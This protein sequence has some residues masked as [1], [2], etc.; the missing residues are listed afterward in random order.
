[1]AFDLS[2]VGARF[3]RLRRHV[4]SLM[5]SVLC[6]S[7]LSTFMKGSSSLSVNRVVHI[8]KGWCS[9][10]PIAKNECLGRHSVDLQSVP[11]H[12]NRLP[13]STFANGQ[14]FARCRFHSS[15][16]STSTSSHDSEINGFSTPGELSTQQEQKFTEQPK[17]HYYDDEEDE[18][19]VAN[20]DSL[21]MG[22]REGFAV[23]HHFE[24]PTM[25]HIDLEALDLAEKDIKRLDLRPSNMTLPV[26]LMLMDP[27]KFSTLS[28][29]R[30][31]CRHGRILLHR[32]PLG[33][34]D[35][36]QRTVFRNEFCTMG[37]VGDRVQP[38]GEI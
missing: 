36:G 33:L 7:F 2:D 4:P 35:N 16:D 28:R 25:D 6:V 14:T 17:D 37:K 11:L 18:I 3:I 27:K 1:M 24:I 22:S 9:S 29:A 19:L 12:K 30:K 8:S 26:A 10:L 15:L 32:G 23:V 21:P 13:F 31:F 20:A 5:G 38:G 34:D